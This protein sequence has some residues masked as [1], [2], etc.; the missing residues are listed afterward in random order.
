MVEGNCRVAR[1]AGAPG[2][3]PVLPAPRHHG[4]PRTPHPA[5]RAAL[6]SLPA[7]APGPHRGWPRAAASCCGARSLFARGLGPPLAAGGA[8]QRQAGGGPAAARP[9]RLA[10]AGLAKQGSNRHSGAGGAGGSPQQLHSRAAFQR[11]GGS[12][13]PVQLAVAQNPQV[14]LCRAAL[15]PP[16]PQPVRRARGVV[17]QV[18]SLALAPLGTSCGWGLPRSP[19]CPDPSA[20]PLRPPGCRRLLPILC[21]QHPEFVFL[22]ALQPRHLQR[23]QRA[24]APGW[25]PARDWPPARCNPSYCD[26]L[27]PARQPI[28]PPRHDVL[29]QLRAGR[30]VR[31]ETVRGSIEGFTDIQEASTEWLPLAS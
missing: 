3:I 31:E 25:I 21:H 7:A 24:P 19:V 12:Q 17:P 26:P 2:S 15:Q 1:G 14:P 6:L 29:I 5:P 10:K 13:A 16:L 18:Q 28:A 11:R 27:G 8:G 20:G 22:P 9:Q 4:P 30:F 23:D